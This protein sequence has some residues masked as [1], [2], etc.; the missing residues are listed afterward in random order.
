MGVDDLD[1]A[2]RTNKESWPVPVAIQRHGWYERWFDYAENL[3]TAK[4]VKWLQFLK[5][6]VFKPLR[7]LQR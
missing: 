3:L 5:D 2:P 1:D 7:F 4:E 6:N